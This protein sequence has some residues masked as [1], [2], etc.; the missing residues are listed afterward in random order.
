M[1]TWLGSGAAAFGLELDF[2]A[3]QRYLPTDPSI[4]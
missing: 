1:R 3:H 2:D 4:G